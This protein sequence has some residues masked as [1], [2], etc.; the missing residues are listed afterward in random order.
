MEILYQWRAVGH[1]RGFLALASLSVEIS[2]YVVFRLLCLVVP[3][4]SIPIYA[5]HSYRPIAGG[6]RSERG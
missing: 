5:V 6:M 3:C 1:Q 2:V 4:L